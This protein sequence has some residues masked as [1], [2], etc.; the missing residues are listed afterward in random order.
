MEAPLASSRSDILCDAAALAFNQNLTEFAAR[1]RARLEFIPNDSHAAFKRYL[2]SVFAGKVSSMVRSSMR[3]RNESPS[4]S[5]SF[6]ASAREGPASSFKAYVFRGFRRYFGV[7]CS[8]S[9][10][11][12]NRHK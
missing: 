2:P 11:D 1:L 8:R 10:T 12:I 4:S 5:M 3:S 9:L 7:A 6:L